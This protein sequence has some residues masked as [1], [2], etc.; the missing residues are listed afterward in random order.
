MDLKYQKKKSFHEE[1]E[2]KK[3]SRFLFRRLPLMVKDEAL[4]NDGEEERRAGCQGDSRCRML[5]A[6]NVKKK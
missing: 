5:H 3:K 1:D 4:E 2:R 6:G